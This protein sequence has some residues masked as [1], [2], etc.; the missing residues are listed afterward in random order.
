MTRIRNPLR[1]KFAAKETAYGLWV[2]LESAT[3]SEIAAEIGLDWICVDMEHGSLD[4]RDV[5]HH[6]RAVRGGDTAVLVRVPSPT[7]D[8]IKRALD[9]GVDGIILPLV[10]SAA[11]LKE[12]FGYARYPT[13]G[14]RAIGGDR[15]VRW[16]LKMDEYLDTANQEI[17][18]IPNIETADASAAITDIL[19]VPG[20]EAIFFGPYDLSASVGHFKLWEG[21]GVAEDILRM[22]KLAADRSIAA[23]VVA[24]GPDDLKQ[25]RAQGFE[26][27]ALGSD[28]TMMIR[29][30][31]GLL[32]AAK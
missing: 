17:L 3:V 11:E 1:R 4:Y 25:R 24:T 29:T 16:G 31:K 5:V 23:G 6:A 20:L 19:A 2:T 22:K 32:D 14:V 7:I 30:I 18:V 9:L 8:S 26:M 10:R 13:T 12:A 15:A 21:P 27:I 28:T